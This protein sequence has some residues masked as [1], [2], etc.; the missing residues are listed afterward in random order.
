MIIYNDGKYSVLFLFV[1][2]LA[3]TESNCYLRMAH[4]TFSER[5]NGGLPLAGEYSSEPRDREEHMP[6]IV[7]DTST[8]PPQLT[9]SRTIME[10]IY[11][12]HIELG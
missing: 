3:K 6:F 9:V 8:F 11:L 10:S 2:M 4:R 5:Y 7:E 12:L 1:K